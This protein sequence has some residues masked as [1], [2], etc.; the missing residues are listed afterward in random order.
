MTLERVI[1][2]RPRTGL[3]IGDTLTQVLVAE[4]LAP[5]RELWLVSGWVSD[6]TVLDNSTGRYNALSSETL[7]HSLSLSDVLASL[8]KAGTELHVAL[9]NDRHNLD[10]LNRLDRAVGES[11]YGRYESADLHEKTL[12]GWSWV[13]TG[14]M[15]FTWNGTERNEESITYRYDVAWAAKHRLE[16]Q[17]RWWS[18]THDR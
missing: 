16:L 13:M 8:V 14:S 6:I 2:T 11:S 17:Q 9:R 18:A 5:S 3:A 15:N 7:P 12:C 1:R 4:L 10:F